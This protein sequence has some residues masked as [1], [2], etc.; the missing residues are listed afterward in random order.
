MFTIS[1]IHHIHVDPKLRYIPEL[2]LTLIPD[3]RF[4]DADLVR[5]YHARQ[6]RHYWSTSRCSICSSRD[7]MIRLVSW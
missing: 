4:G 3:D 6:D 2:N 5:E 7:G 1:R